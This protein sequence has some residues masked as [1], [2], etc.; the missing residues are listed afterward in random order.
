MVCTTRSTLA[1]LHHSGIDY[2]YTLIPLF[3]QNSIFFALCLLFSV[4]LSAQEWS[5]QYPFPVL[6]SLQE[7]A[8]DP[9]GHGWAVGSNSTILHSTN[10]GASWEIQEAPHAQVSLLSLAIDPNSNGQKAFIGGNLLLKTEDGGQTWENLIGST[11]PINQIQIINSDIIYAFGHNNTNKKSSD[12]GNTWEDVN[13]PSGIGPCRGYFLDELNGWASDGGFNNTKLYRTHDGG[14]NWTLLDTTPRNGIIGLYMLN[15]NTGFMSGGQQVLKTTDGGEHWNAI[16]E[17]IPQGITDLHIVN[18]DEIWASIFNGQVYRTFNGGTDWTLY[19]PAL[20]NASVAVKY[21][22][23]Y[24]ITGGQAWIAG[25]Y[26]TIPYTSDGGQTWTDQVPGNKNHL[27]GIDFLDENFGLACGIGG[28]ILT[29]NNGGAIWE[30]ISIGGD[31]LFFDIKIADEQTIYAGQE[32]HIVK[33][34]DGAQS[35]TTISASDMTNIRGLELLDNNHLVAYSLGGNVYV[36][37]NG[38]DSWTQ[39]NCPLNNKRDIHFFSNEIGWLSSNEGILF[40]TT[41]GGLNWEMI[42]TQIDDN[43]EGIYQLDE[44]NIWVLSNSYSGVLYHSADGGQNWTSIDI[45]TSA[46]WNQVLFVDPETAWLFGGSSGVNLIFEST[47]GGQ[48]WEQNYRDRALINSVCQLDNGKIWAAGTAANILHLAP[49]SAPQISNLTGPE[50]LCEGDEVSYQIDSEDATNYNWN[51]PSDWTLISNDNSALIEL[52]V[53][54]QSGQISIVAGNSCETSSEELHLAVNV[55]TAIDVT[56]EISDET[57]LTVS[58]QG[59]SYTWMLAGEVIEQNTSN[60]WV[61]TEPGL[62]SVIVSFEEGCDAVSDVVNVMI[63]NTDEVTLAQDIQIYPNPS[64]GKVNIQLASALQIKSIKLY[65]QTGQIIQQSALT[66]LDY[67]HLAK[68]LYFLEIVTNEGRVFKKL[69][70]K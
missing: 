45:G 61:A 69:I 9:N 13:A 34:T 31:I 19:S 6:E 29:T 38:G 58:P 68:G 70:L 63:S 18:E 26:S 48:T 7:I 55:Q 1:V 25:D 64:S 39:A 27:Y 22:N 37:E 44:N 30:D 12:G 53:G 24:A 15:E 14:Q 67:R 4:Q 60:T 21:Q 5:R 47:D 66:P 41:D 50:L 11:N 32:G 51:Y 56:L 2:L 40:K 54:N 16:S 23:I 10:W 43:L 62:Y 46:F 3:M 59:E 36:S 20:D 17:A 28:T 33:S 57:T 35:W 8:F 42:D 65:N 52:L 49:C